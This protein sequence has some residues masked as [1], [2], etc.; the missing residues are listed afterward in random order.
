MSK[1][2]VLIMLFELYHMR[3][4][5]IL[6]VPFETSWHQSDFCEFVDGLKELKLFF[7]RNRFRSLSNNSDIQGF[8][9]LLVQFQQSKKIVY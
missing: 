6:V 3:T 5:L 7:W 8:L 1:F 9:K 2:V 4:P